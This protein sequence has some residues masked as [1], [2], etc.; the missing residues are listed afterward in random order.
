MLQK[1]KEIPGLSNCTKRV[2]P[3]S[4]SPRSKRFPSNNEN[5]LW[6]K[7]SWLGNSTFPPAGITSS[8]GRKLLSFCTS[9]GISEICCCGIGGIGV[10]PAGVGQTTSF[11]ASFTPCPLLVSCTLPLSSTCWVEA[12]ADGNNRTH[13]AIRHRAKRAI[14]KESPW[15]D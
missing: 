8:E 1:I 12:S 4:Y 11:E 14:R 10:F 5:T 7:G 9:W 15:R 13:A 6:K 2:V 3:L